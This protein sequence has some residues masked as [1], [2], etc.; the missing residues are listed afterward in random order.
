MAGLGM[1]ELMIA[2]FILLV[3]LL[4]MAGLQGTALRNNHSAYMRSQAMIYA[5]DIL[6]RLRANKVAALAGNY[7]RAL[8]DAVPSQTC[9]TACTPSNMADADI[10]QWIGNV[11]TLPSG[12]GSIA[13][14]NAG[15]ATIVIQWDDTRD[16][17]L[18]NFQLT[19]Q[20]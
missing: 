16:N 18:T 17:N 3:G 20:L 9:T 5:Y 4:G 12:D 1:I 2:F 15:A 13:V 19:T 6:D 7:A 14:T 11:S 10:N 8:G